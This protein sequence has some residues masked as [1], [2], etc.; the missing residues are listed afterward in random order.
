[1]GGFWPGI[2]VVKKGHARD[3]HIFLVADAQLLALQTS[4]PPLLSVRA[5]IYS[6]L[7]SAFHRLSAV[8]APL[9]PTPT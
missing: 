8:L 2:Y 3:S 9:T 5:A 7:A 4:A 1:M 6:L